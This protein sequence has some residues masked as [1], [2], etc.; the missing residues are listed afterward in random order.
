MTAA[1]LLH[2][3][4]LTKAFGGLRALD[5]IDIDVRP[6]EIVGLVGPNGAGKTAL[7][8]TITGFYRATSGSIV[9]KGTDVT[10]LPMQE[11][12]RIGISRT[13]QNIRLFKRMTV[14]ENALTAYKPFV[15]RPLWSLVSRAEKRQATEHAMQWLSLLQLADKTNQL[16]SSLSYGDARRLEIARALVGKPDLLLLDEPAAGMN[17]AET[18]RLSEDILAVR[19]HVRAMLLIEHDMTLI[20]HLSDRLIAMDYG[21]KIAEGT[22]SDVLS[23]PQVLKAYLG[24]DTN[25]APT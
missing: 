12:G 22:P 11:I 18:R 4:S 17:D 20:R 8:N 1:P 5:G 9:F 23:H 14:L 25:E 19:N 21:R 15:T 3:R 7:I 13:F 10:R 24:S 6:G 2:I 16:A